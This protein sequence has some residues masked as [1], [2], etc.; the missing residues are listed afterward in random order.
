MESSQ[1]IKYGALM[2]YFSLGINII[3]GLIYTPWMISS[4][5][6][7]NYGLYTLALSVITLFVFDFGLS[8][9]VTRFLSKYLAE[10]RQD[11]A[12]EFLGLVYR[13]YLYID[14][15]LFLILLAVFFFIPEIYRELTPEEVD[16][17]K[18]IY[19]I[20]ALFTVLSFPFIPLNGILTANEKFIQLKTCEV[21]NKL[22]IVGSMAVCLLLG[23][24]L[25]ALV[26]VNA[27]A[28][29]VMIILKI[30]IIKRNTNTRVI[31]GFRN[32]QQFRELIDFS[33]WTAVIAVC[34]R[35][36]F[37]LAPTILGFFSGSA[38]IAIFGIAN[39]IE[40]YVFSFSNALSG[41]FLPRVFRI[42]S[43]E[44]GDIMPLMIKV[45]RIQLLVVG[46]VVLGFVCAGQEFITLWVG[47]D[48]IESY[49]CIVLLVIPSLIQLPQEIGMQTI[50]AEN[51]VKKQA[52]VWM[53]VALLNILLSIVLTWKYNVFGLCLSICVSFIVRTIGMDII[54]K[55]DLH[56]NLWLFFSNTFLPIGCMLLLVILVSFSFN[57][58]VSGSIIF[59]F[60]IKIT[61]FLFLYTIGFLIVGNKE[62]KKLIRS[63]LKIK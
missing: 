46:A 18:V 34:Q 29:I 25:Y 56:L 61:I 42:I 48:F 63:V 16:K 62:E 35:F 57:Y 11:K 28:G 20:A 24:G 33:A 30:Y 19:V 53:F 49:A 47:A 7:E 51:K 41:M 3:A 31:F 55:K 5:G 14:I 36:F 59:T 9:A 52:L 44:G 10:N 8:S 38:A 37:T 13:L 6:K 23:Y 17:F 60:L 43:R 58:I 40:G 26:I 21:V 1:Q 12:N 32:R 22:L 45:G 50:I 54:L 15:L 39:T 4:I 27:L 2:S